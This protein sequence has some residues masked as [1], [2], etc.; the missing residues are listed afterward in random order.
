MGDRRI[1]V[2][3]IGNILM[4]DDGI[5]VW[6]VK[7]LAD[8]YDIPP[9]MEVM[10]GGIAGLR[11][12]GELA[13]VSHLLSVDAIRGGGPPSAIYRLDPEELPRNRGPFLSAHEVGIAELLSTAEFSAKLPKTRIIGVEPLQTEAMGLELT[14]PLR[15]A[16]PRIL[17][18]VAEE[19]SRMGFPLKKKPEARGRKGKAAR[20]NA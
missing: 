11:L 15:A 2:L 14:Q 7:L 17:S 18:A 8:G 16:L 5:G 1:L 19:L 3:G 10:E 20:I 12:L 9:N 6:A 13:E 4:R